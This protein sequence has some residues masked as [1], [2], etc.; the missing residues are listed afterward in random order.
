[1][2]Q[3]IVTNEFISLL[4]DDLYELLFDP[5]FFGERALSR[6]HESDFTPRIVRLEHGKIIQAKDPACRLFKVFLYPTIGRAEVWAAREWEESLS[7]RIGAVKQ[8]H[9]DILA[10]QKASE[11]HKAIT[12]YV[13]ENLGIRKDNP[14]HH[15]LVTLF[16]SL[17][18]VPNELKQ[19]EGLEELI[20]QHN[21]NSN[22]NSAK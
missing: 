4:P 9:E 11:K 19:F 8:S 20:N 18:Y 16:K 22:P 3:P 21:G 2:E 14:A 5:P 17:S 7:K 15:R 6:A 13:E 1:M 12:V 10:Y